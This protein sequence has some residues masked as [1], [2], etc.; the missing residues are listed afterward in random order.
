MK[1]VLIERYKFLIYVIFVINNIC[2]CSSCRFVQNDYIDTYE[3]FK[4]ED[5]NLK[6]TKSHEYDAFLF[7]TDPHCL[8]Y[9]YDTISWE[10][11]LNKKIDRIEE[12]Y[13]LSK[14]QFVVSGGDW[15]NCLDTQDEA[16][17]K[18]KK[19]NERFKS[20]FSLSYLVLGN[21]DTNYQGYKNMKDRELG[22]YNGTL[23]NEEILKL[24]FSEFGNIYYK[25]QTKNTSYYVLNTGIEWQP[26]MDE[27]RWSQL[28]WLAKELK[29]DD[30]KHI[31]IFQH[32]VL[33]NNKLFDFAI[34]EG[35]LLEAYNS[36]SLLELGS[37][38]KFDFTDCTGHVDFIMAG[39]THKDTCVIVGGV[40]AI[41]VRTAKEEIPSFDLVLVDYAENKIY[42]ERFGKG[43]NREF[44]LK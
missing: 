5:F 37:G 44:V 36:R 12:I 10:E 40:P 15:L 7:F 18:L 6:C 2:L 23:S 31:S 24:L 3:E 29:S 8:G 22:K 28:E 34:Y 27:Y 42:C 33:S 13:S 9:W 39:H 17:C 30:S 14:A 19:T 20:S 4:V 43:N 1:L 16:K 32:I 26:K 38:E 11:N 25:F 41:I 21:H 35:K